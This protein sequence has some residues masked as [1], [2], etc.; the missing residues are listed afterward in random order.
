MT[1]DRLLEALL[2]MPSLP[3]EFGDPRYR[4]EFKKHVD[5]VV[6]FSSFPQRQLL[7]SEG[8][9]ADAMYFVD[10]GAARGYT[11]DPKSRREIT[12]FLWE[13]RSFVVAANS[14][15]F[16]E[17]SDIYIEV[18]PGSFLLSATYQDMLTT[19]AKFPQV[20]TMTRIVMVQYNKFYAKRVLE[21][22]TLNAWDRYLNLLKEHPGIEQKVSQDIIASFVGVTPQSLSRMIGIHGHP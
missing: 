8:Q 1:T 16:R 13:E 19:F 12:L 6:S 3:E 22:M 15:F 11:Y 10:K 20:E 9:K 5:K 4:T 21:L 17:P 2:A 7:L 18:L 14:F